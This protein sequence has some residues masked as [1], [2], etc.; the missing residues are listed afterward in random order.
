MGVYDKFPREVLFP[1]SMESNGASNWEALGPF[2][3]LSGGVLFALRG[4]ERFR[5]CLGPHVLPAKPSIWCCTAVGQRN[6][7]S[8]FQKIKMPDAFGR[9]KQKCQ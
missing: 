6:R 3:F 9:L 4:A 8:L 7:V 1:C 5:L 2:F